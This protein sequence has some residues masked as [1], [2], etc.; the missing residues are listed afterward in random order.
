[1]FLDGNKT[2][3]I[4]FTHGKE[5]LLNGIEYIGPYHLWVDKYYYT[6]NFHDKKISKKLDFFLDNAQILNYNKLESD[7]IKVKWIYPKQYIASPTQ[8]DYKKGYIERCF[9]RKAN[10]IN[11]E[12]I[13]VSIDDGK[14]IN[15]QQY[16]IVVFINWKISGVLDNFRDS[17]GALYIGVLTSNHIE[18]EK[19]EKVMPGIKNVLSYNLMEFYK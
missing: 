18:V 19:A 13:E 15:A 3:K 14:Y 16:Y 9:V 4:K 10:D 8:D 5:F 11:A 12:I 17:C 1:M 2:I 7:F 6:G